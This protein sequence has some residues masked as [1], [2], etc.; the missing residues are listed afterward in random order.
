MATTM[1]QL[2]VLT[3][4]GGRSGECAGG[5]ELVAHVA[6]AAGKVVAFPSGVVHS[7]VH[8]EAAEAEKR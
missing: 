2:R 4:N 6:S 1:P 5:S 7:G 8:V 3:G